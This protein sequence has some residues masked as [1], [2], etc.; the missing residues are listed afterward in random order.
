MQLNKDM[1]SLHDKRI[2]QIYVISICM[3]IRYTS[4][5]RWRK[6]IHLRSLETLLCQVQ[7]RDNK[8]ENNDAVS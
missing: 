1:K 5:C 3:K 7:N 2:F 6:W 8:T 4:V